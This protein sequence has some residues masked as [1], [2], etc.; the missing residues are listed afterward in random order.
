MR[1]TPRK[2]E[3]IDLFSSLLEMYKVKYNPNQL[4]EMK[5]TLI[6]FDKCRN[7][8]LNIEPS[9]EILAELDKKF[10]F[11]YTYR[12]ILVSLFRCFDPV[13]RLCIN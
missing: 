9:M 12:S 7:E 3:K 11:A 1:P 5:Q 4:E 2:T 8:L 6:E 10:E 13:F